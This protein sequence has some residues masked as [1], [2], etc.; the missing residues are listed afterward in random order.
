MHDQVVHALHACRSEDDL[1][2][3]LQALAALRRKRLKVEGTDEIEELAR[4]IVFDEG[5]SYNLI[6]SMLM[7]DE[8]VARRTDRSNC[9][10]AVE[11][12]NSKLI[13]WPDS[14]MWNI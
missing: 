7:E 8:P 13:F 14:S 3:P 2:K 11:A 6:N 10:A 5:V 1:G 4:D 9:L 12:K